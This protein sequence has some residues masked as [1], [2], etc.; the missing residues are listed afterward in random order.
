MLLLFQILPG[1]FVTKLSTYCCSIKLL[2]SLNREYKVEIDEHTEDHFFKVGSGQWPLFYRRVFR[3]DRDISTICLRLVGPD[4]FK[5]MCFRSDGMEVGY[6]SANRLLVEPSLA[7]RCLIKGS[8]S[9][10]F[11]E[12]IF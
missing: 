1:V 6:D 9:T 10:S 5:V 7:N 12:V 8:G 3:N 2:D 4:V 11:K